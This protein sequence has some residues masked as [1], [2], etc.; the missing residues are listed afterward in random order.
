MKRAIVAALAALLLPAGAIA[1]GG[2]LDG[3]GGHYNRKTGSYHC[4]REPCFSN[5][6]GEKQEKP[7]PKKPE[8]KEPKSPPPADDGGDIKL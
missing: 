7:T 3:N 5:A 6:R 8:K 1:H 4:H 2:G